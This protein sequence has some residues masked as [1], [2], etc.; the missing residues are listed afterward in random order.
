MKPR[1]AGHLHVSRMKVP[2]SVKYL[3]A[4]LP[5]VMV[6][7]WWRLADWAHHYFQCYGLKQMQPCLAGP[8][9][10]TGFVAT[11]MFF[12]ALLWIPAAILSVVLALAVGE[13][14]NRERIANGPSPKTHVLCP[15]CH[16]IIPVEAS[17]C[18]HCLCRLVPQ[19]PPHES[20]ND[21]G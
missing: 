10:L 2:W 5:F 6:F 16:K 1:S 8:V 17:V 21:N 13:K 3:V 4:S 19:S 9:N 18:E 20:V 15:E 12:G 7:G 14:H 11:G